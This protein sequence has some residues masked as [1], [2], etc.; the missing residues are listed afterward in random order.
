MAML[1]YDTVADAILANSAFREMTDEKRS[2]HGRTIY[3]GPLRPKEQLK[4]GSRAT[5]AYRY[6]QASFPAHST[7]IERDFNNATLY[8]EKEPLLR[9]KGDEIIT[10]CSA[11]P[12]DL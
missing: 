7:K 12:Q 10:L 11:W 9:L 4:Q 2:L 5:V 6:L 1:E 8:Y 3:S